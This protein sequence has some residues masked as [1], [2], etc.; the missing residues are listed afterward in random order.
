[1]VDVYQTLD[2]SF[3]RVKSHWVLQHT[4]T[5]DSIEYLHH[6]QNKRAGIWL[7]LPALCVQFSNRSA[8]GEYYIYN[9]PEGLTNSIYQTTGAALGLVDIFPA[10]KT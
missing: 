5:R 2:S 8:Q 4:H 9:Q 7:R 3:V 6:D 10:P 1:M